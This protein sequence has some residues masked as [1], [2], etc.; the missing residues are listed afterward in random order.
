MHEKIPNII[1]RQKIS[2]FNLIWFTFW[3]KNSRENSNKTY[4][5]I[6]FES[7]N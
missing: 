7:E 6:E 1:S 3:K 4:K 5:K 2:H